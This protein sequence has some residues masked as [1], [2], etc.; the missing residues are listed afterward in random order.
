MGLKDEADVSKADLFIDGNGFHDLHQK[1]TTYDEANLSLDLETLKSTYG[2]DL[3]RKI[4][5]SAPVGVVAGL[6]ALA[7]EGAD[8][9]NQNASAGF[10]VVKAAAADAAFAGAVSAANAAAS[11]AAM[12]SAA[13]SEASP[14]VARAAEQASA[15]LGAWCCSAKPA[16]ATSESEI[17][18][19][20]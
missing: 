6:R 10:A 2:L 20:A 5:W 8:V 18:E 1:A 16:V 9:E 13:A 3:P 7:A 12:V 17:V 14:V 11:G 19:I 15:T 4:N